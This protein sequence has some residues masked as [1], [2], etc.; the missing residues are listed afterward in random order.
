[1]KLFPS[2]PLQQFAHPIVGALT[3]F[4]GDRLVYVGD[5]GC[6]ADKSFHDELER[7]WQ[8]HDVVQIPTWP[9]IHDAVY[10]YERKV[11]QWKPG[12]AERRPNPHLSSTG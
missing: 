11:E 9:G 8:L 5:A 2:R 3:A 1:M 6:S 12:G 10:L 7:H 4:Q